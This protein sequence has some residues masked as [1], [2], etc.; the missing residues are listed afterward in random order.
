MP[1]IF[2]VNK[3]RRYLEE[4]DTADYQL[5]VSPAGQYFTIENKSAKTEKIIVDYAK[6]HNLEVDFIIDRKGFVIK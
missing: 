1:N 5:H 2:E 4:N 3:M 6:K